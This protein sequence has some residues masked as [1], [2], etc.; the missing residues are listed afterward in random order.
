MN[1][2]FI[3][4]LAL[5]LLSGCDRLYERAGL[6]DPAKVLAE[7]KAIGGACRH[8]GRG[9]ED[10]F[11]LNPTASKSAIYE[12]WK[13]MNEYM[14]KNGLEAIPPQIDPQARSKSASKGQETEAE[15]EDEKTVQG[16]DA[17][18]HDAGKG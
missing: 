12:G 6:P 5:I 9:L 3:L 14:A 11:A 17:P 4:P 16:K 8:A 15:G 1:R 18:G 13:E 7:G 10:C 2:I